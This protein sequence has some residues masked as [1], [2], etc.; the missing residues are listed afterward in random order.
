MN[1]T[2]ETINTEVPVEKNQSGI[3]SGFTIA[4]LDNGD[5][6]FQVHGPSSTGILELLGLLEV[7]S[8]MIKEEATSK[9]RGNPE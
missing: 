2:L 6:A 4:V 3:R 9:L 7:A 1:K 8:L 5:F